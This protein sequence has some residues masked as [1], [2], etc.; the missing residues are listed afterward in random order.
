MPIVSEAQR[1]A[2]W[3][4]AE[5]R[6][7]L[8]IPKKVG[9]ECVAADAASAGIAAGIVFVAPDGD[10]LLMRRAGQAG[11]D[12]FVGH[13]SLPGGKGEPGETPE[14]AARR[15]SAEELG[16]MAPDGPMKLLDMQATPTGMVFFTFTQPVDTK[17]WPRI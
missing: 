12:N 2:M 16:N 6:S 4:A 17:F 1:R 7:T 9:K 15:E 13:W 8:G 11:V 3:A 14:E 5:G 10:I